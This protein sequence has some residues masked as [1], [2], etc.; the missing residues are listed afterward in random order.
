MWGDGDTKT[1][2]DGKKNLN[3]VH[4]QV[5][6]M[7]KLSNFPQS[8]SAGAHTNHLVKLS[9]TNNFYSLLL[10]IILLFWVGGGSGEMTK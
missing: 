9:L 8:P 6:G 3:F 7:Q 4:S 10:R 5:V 1:I 2:L